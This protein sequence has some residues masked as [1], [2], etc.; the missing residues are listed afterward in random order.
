MLDEREIFKRI[1]PPATGA[2]NASPFSKTTPISGSNQPYEP[3]AGV[4]PLLLS[5]S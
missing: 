4:K 1:P 5:P 3:D 2:S